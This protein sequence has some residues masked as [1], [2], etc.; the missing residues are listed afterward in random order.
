MEIRGKVKLEKKDLFLFL[1]HHMYFNTTGI[2]YSA[3][4]VFAF[5]GGIYYLV[6][7]NRSGVYL[8]LISLVYFV[9]MPLMLYRKAVDQSKNEILSKETS[10]ILN[11][12]GIHAFQEGREPSDAPWQDITRIVYFAGEFFIYISRVRANILPAS[13][14]DKDTAEIKAL[15]KKV[16]PKGR[17]KGIR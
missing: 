14:F 17:L 4:A 16:M 13:A 5:A 11:E 1:L 7:G 2:I 15:F 10:Y 9:L 12:E 6:N 8:L 3:I